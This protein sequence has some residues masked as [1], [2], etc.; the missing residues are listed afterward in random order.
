MLSGITGGASLSNG[1]FSGD[2]TIASTQYE[3]NLDITETLTS[4]LIN[5]LS[6]VDAPL[7]FTNGAASVDIDTIF[8]DIEGIIDFA[9]GDLDFDLT[10]PFGK[11]E[12]SIDFPENSQFEVPLALGGLAPLN[13]GLDLAAG[14][15]VIPLFG[16]VELGLET[17]SGE[18]GFNEGLADLSLN[19]AGLPAPIETT[20]ET[21][22][23]AEQL[24]TEL[25]EDFSGE[26]VIDS[27][28]LNG[29]IASRFGE[30]PVT[31][32]ID[33]VLLQT[34]NVIDKTTGSLT[35]SD[36]I[37]RL[38]LNTSFG[39]LLGELALAPLESALVSASNL[40]T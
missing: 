38:D 15:L 18:L 36:G 10:T 23:L 28:G 27:K 40:L 2:V 30:F 37:A 6:T 32:S 16:G 19:I 12:T 3:V 25:V 35:L 26:L 39:N 33:D 21:G 4:T 1:Q 31:A 34:S 29:S 8:G 20:F 9:G 5:L 17:L 13:L 14:V 11:L 22:P 24:V 7:S